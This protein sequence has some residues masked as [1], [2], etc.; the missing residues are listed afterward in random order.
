ME[1][2][3]LESEITLQESNLSGSDGVKVKLPQ[4]VVHGNIT[5]KRALEP[6]SEQFTS[7]VNKCFRFMEN[8]FISPC[9][10]IISLMDSQ[11]Q[12]LA[13]WTCTR[14][15]PVKWNLGTLDAQ[16]SGLA[17]ETLVITYNIL[18]RKNNG[19]DSERDSSKYHNRKKSSGGFRNL[20]YHLQK[21]RRRSYSKNISKQQWIYSK[22][23]GKEKE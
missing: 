4:A 20:R 17:I 18:E 13:S 6:T 10:M 16:K 7:W 2:N 19:I 14:A 12:A 8:G 9:D 22:D 23:F 21:N 1:V 5:L 15:Y 3:G 11:N